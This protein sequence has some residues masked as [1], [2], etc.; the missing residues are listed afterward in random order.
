MWIVLALIIPLSEVLLKLSSR[1]PVA[2]RTAVVL[3]QAT[4]VLCL[5]G[6]KKPFRRRLLGPGITLAPTPVS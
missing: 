6:K 4:D 1:P 2:T 3:S 5:P